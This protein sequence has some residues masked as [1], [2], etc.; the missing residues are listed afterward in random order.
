M[1]FYSDAGQDQFVANL[2]GFKRDGYSV[3]I[4]SAGSIWSNNTYTFQDLDWTSITV[5]INS[6]Y[7]STY[8]T[9]KK[10][11]HYNEDA[12]KINYQKIFEENEF[13][14]NIDYLS[15][16]V[17]TLS[18]DVLKFLPFDK[19]TFKCITIEHDAYLYGDTYRA[20]QREIL[21]E[22]G[23]DLV[24]ANV[25]VPNPGHQGYKGDP[26]PF[27]DW[28][29]NPSDFDSELLDKIRSES[30]FPVEII[31]KSNQLNPIN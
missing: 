21:K 1:N 14:S 4:G 18:L 3:D 10:G 25:L 5:E 24:C 15:L 9:R 13:P 23:Y 11:T 26:C 19:Y 12:L 16:D 22:N 2:L 30:L 27:E 6:K 28:W 7:N 17:D 29:V 20:T 8:G 31:A